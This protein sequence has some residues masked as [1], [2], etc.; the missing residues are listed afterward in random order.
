MYILNDRLRNKLVALMEM[1]PDVPDRTK[2]FL[3]ALYIWTLLVYYFTKLINLILEMIIS[4]VPN[5]LILYKFNYI[6]QKKGN[7]VNV[8]QARDK[9]GNFITNKLNLYM[10]LK[11]DKEL[12]TQSNGGV[13]LDNFSK[14]IGSSVIWIA[15]LLECDQCN[16][17]KDAIESLNKQDFNLYKM[18]NLIKIMILDFSNKLIYKFGKNDDVFQT[19]NIVFGE[20]NFT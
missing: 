1:L 14:Y 12:N 13:D 19:E 11:W 15:Y 6:G 18:E 7:N 16:E 10:N 3:M 4:Y 20:I 2:M 17:Y 8:I 5:N 9:F